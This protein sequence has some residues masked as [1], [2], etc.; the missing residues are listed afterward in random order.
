M[1]L[2]ERLS[3]NCPFG[4]NNSAGKEWI[5]LCNSYLYTI[6]VVCI[7]ILNL[8]T[9]LFS[10]QIGCRK[11]LFPFREIFC[12]LYHLACVLQTKLAIAKM[13][14]VLPETIHQNEW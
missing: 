11:S 3:N 2:L 9:C 4:P 14:A 6:Q 12:L 1:R 8:I 7:K 13:T 10:E 5:E